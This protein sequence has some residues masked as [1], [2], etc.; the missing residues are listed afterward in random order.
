[1]FSHSRGWRAV[2]EPKH[3]KTPRSAF[4]L[5]GSP[6]RQRQGAMPKGLSH[7]G[8]NFSIELRRRAALVRRSTCAWRLPVLLGI[9]LGNT[10]EWVGHTE[11]APRPSIISST[12]KNG[13]LKNIH[14]GQVRVP[15]FWAPWT[16][17]WSC[18]RSEPWLGRGVPRFSG[19]RLFFVRLAFDWARPGVVCFRWKAGGNLTEGEKLGV[20]Q[21]GLLPPIKSAWGLAN[22]SL[23]SPAAA[24]SQ[25]N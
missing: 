5:G 2:E 1:L 18:H 3:A 6:Q 23:F 14:S 13:E 21:L 10:E 16:D 22:D 7:R 4:P 9:V 17:R 11:V 8:P 15:S 19:A 25:P 24:I 20:T 12:P